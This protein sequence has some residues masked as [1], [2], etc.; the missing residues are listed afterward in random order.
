[1][2]FGHR[3]GELDSFSEDMFGKNPLSASVGVETAGCT[4]LPIGLMVS[5]LYLKL[6]YDV[7]GLELSRRL[8]W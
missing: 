4:R 6:V 3:I 2:V 5:F 8:F 7:N 1:V